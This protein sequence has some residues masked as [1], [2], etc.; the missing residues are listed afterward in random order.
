LERQR[1]PLAPPPRHKQPIEAGSRKTHNDNHHSQK[2]KTAQQAPLLQSNARSEYLNA[3]L[4]A[5]LLL[6]SQCRRA[7]WLC[8]MA[9]ATHLYCGCL[10][11]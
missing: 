2:N 9:R 10:L 8:A 11:T 4:L 7:R 3:S 6:G 1:L 5:L